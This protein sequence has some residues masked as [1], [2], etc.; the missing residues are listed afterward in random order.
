MTIDL[1]INVISRKHKIRFLIRKSGMEWKGRN[2]L[3]AFLPELKSDPLRSQNTSFPSPDCQPDL[4][5][6][7]N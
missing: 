1:K 3:K 2:A 7:K 4:R 5:K 6:N